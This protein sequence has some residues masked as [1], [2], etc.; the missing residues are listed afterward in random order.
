MGE[1]D[2]NVAVVTGAGGE[3]I[4]AGI[5]AGL[6]RE[7]AAVVI[8]DIDESGAQATA[9]RISEGGVDTLAIAHDVTKPESCAGVVEATIERFGRIDTLVNNAGIASR[10][11]FRELDEDEWDRMMDVNLKGVYLMTRAVLE[12]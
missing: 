11:A 5:A 1:L 10:C 8:T 2:R 3:G 9:A 6:A 12:A 7:G 4:G